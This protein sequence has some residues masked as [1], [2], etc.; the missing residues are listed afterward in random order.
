MQVANTMTNKS[1]LMLLL[2]CMFRL[3]SRKLAIPFFKI[4]LSNNWSNWVSQEW[5][6]KGI[7]Y[8][9]LSGPDFYSFAKFERYSSKVIFPGDEKIVVAIQMVFKQFANN[10]FKISFEKCI[11]FRDYCVSSKG[12]YFTNPFMKMKTPIFFCILLTKFAKHSL[13][14]GY[15]SKLVSSRSLT[16]NV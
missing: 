9:S 4:L 11:E 7:A 3:D 10:Y 15:A 8:I 12:R 14:E 16:L 5:I 13:Y 2:L 1:F 6:I